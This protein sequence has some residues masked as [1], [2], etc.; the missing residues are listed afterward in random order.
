MR[1]LC[2]A[3]QV[4]ACMAR[5]YDLYGRLWKLKLERQSCSRGVRRQPV[6]GQV[7]AAKIASVQ[8]D[9]RCMKG[10]RRVVCCRV[11]ECVGGL[12]KFT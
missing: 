9:L 5:A 3:G 10:W 6:W 2:R 11:A 8:R 12:H 7:G 4:D 1:L